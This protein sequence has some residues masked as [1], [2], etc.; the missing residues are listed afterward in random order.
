MLLHKYFLTPR[1]RVRGRITSA[2]S[3]EDVSPNEFSAI[4]LYFPGGSSL[5]STRR[6]REEMLPFLMSVPLVT[7]KLFFS[8]LITGGGNPVASQ[9][10]IT[11]IA[12]SAR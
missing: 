10:K 9:V 6:T 7:V 5:F 4:H 12:L 11:A 2:A 1:L 3:L 8:Q